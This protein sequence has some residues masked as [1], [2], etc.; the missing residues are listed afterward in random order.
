MSISLPHLATVLPQGRSPGRTMHAETVSVVARNAWHRQ[1]SIEGPGHTLRAMRADE[2]RP[3]ARIGIRTIPLVGAGASILDPLDDVLDD[4]HREAPTRFLRIDFHQPSVVQ[5][6]ELGLLYDGP[7]C[8]DWSEAVRVEVRFAGE[9][10]ARSFTLHASYVNAGFATSSWDGS[11]MPWICSGIWS[12]GPGLW[13]NAD[14]F[15]SR[16]VERI[17]LV[18]ALSAGPGGESRPRDS[19]VVF[20]SLEAIGVPDAASRALFGVE[21]TPSPQRA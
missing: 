4:E 21:P 20:R 15:A 1:A 5:N 7:E 11:A 12:G 19:A 2:L 14:P 3:G 17:D 18:V 6:L 16:L 10:T 9:T 13:L 8:A